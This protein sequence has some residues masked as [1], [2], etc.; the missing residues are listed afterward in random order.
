MYLLNHVE[1]TW[2]AGSKAT[3][4]PKVQAN[5]EYFEKNKDDFQTNMKYCGEGASY[6]TQEEQTHACREALVYLEALYNFK[7][8]HNNAS[9]LIAEPYT[10]SKYD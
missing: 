2:V 10:F 9:G 4:S 6:L 7:E 3:P 1:I 8:A 5:I